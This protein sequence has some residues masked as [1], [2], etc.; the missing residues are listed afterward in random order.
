M[1]TL[2]LM[3]LAA[4]SMI[5]AGVAD[6]Q[7][8]Q[9]NGTV[10]SNRGTGS[11]SASASCAGGT[12]SRSVNRTGAAGRTMSNSGSVTK[13]GQGQ[14]SYSGSTTGPNGNTRTRSGSV[15]VTNGQ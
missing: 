13:T 15:T 14:Y 4:V 6:A 12:C 2:S 10:S 11:Y 5:F 9:R 7:A 8:F 1:K 3:S